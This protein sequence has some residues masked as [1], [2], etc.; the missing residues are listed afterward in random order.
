[1]LAFGALYGDAE[2]P[3]PKVK[4]KRRN[5]EEVEQIKFNTWF[6]EVLTIKGCRWFHSPNG[7][8][9]S[10]IEGAKFKRMGVKRGVPDIIIPMPRVGSRSPYHGLVIELKR[11]DGKMSDVSE[12][13]KDWL[14]WFKTQGW[15]THVAFGFEQAK[16]I[17]L[18]YF[19]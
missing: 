11:P 3:K 17:V 1:M 15:S 19:A 13:Q 5:I 12:E 7:G 9:R 6:E 10:L 18:D 14:E 8:G 16:A 4:T 2:P